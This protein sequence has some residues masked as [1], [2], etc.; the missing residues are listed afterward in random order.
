MVAAPGVQLAGHT[1]PCSSVNCNAIAAKGIW[2][3]AETEP[4]TSE[5]S[6]SKWGVKHTSMHLGQA[7]QPRCS[8]TQLKVIYIPLSRHTHPAP[9]V[10]H[11]L[12]FLLVYPTP[13]AFDC[14]A[15][16]PKCTLPAKPP[17]TK[18][19]Q[20]LLGG[21]S[22]ATRARARTHTRIHTHTQMR[23]TRPVPLAAP[24]P[25]L[26]CVPHGP[27]LECLDQPECLINTAAHR[28]VVHGLL[29]QCAIRGNDEQATAAT[30]G[31]Q[32]V[33]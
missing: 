26:P 17:H 7:A 15:V 1:S 25:C 21:C 32:E 10:C 29:A 16:S 14:Y 33:R 4:S 23:V 2:S 3:R 28:Q 30:Q 20:R 22:I 27:H 6:P 8:G 11:T 31:R 24:H 9:V 18:C 12:C 13:A 19:A 5:S